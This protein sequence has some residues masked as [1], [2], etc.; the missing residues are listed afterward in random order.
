MN[1]WSTGRAL[2]LDISNDSLQDAAETWE[3]ELT[4]YPLRRA[5]L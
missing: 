5:G 1:R 2:S 4:A 3:S